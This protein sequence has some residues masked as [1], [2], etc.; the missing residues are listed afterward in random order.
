[1]DEKTNEPKETT[2]NKIT[3]PFANT[4]SNLFGKDSIFNTD[5]GTKPLFSFLNNETSIFGNKDNKI[6]PTE[7]KILFNFN[8]NR[9]GRMKFPYLNQRFLI[10][11]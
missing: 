1:L 7:K 9:E 4:T 6:D 5:N 10:L 2:E 8:T 11:N 3:N